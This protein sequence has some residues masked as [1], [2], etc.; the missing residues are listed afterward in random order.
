MPCIMHTNLTVCNNGYLAS[1]DKSTANCKTDVIFQQLY[2]P[3]LLAA[4]TCVPAA[5]LFLGHA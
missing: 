5:V 2:L 3:Q 1:R 4:M